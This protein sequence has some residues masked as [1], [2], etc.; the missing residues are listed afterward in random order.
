MTGTQ[1]IVVKDG[2]GC[3]SAAQ[4]FTLTQP[5]GTDTIRATVVAGPIKCNGDKTTVTVSATG[6]TPPYTGAGTF[7]VGAGTYTYKVTDSK[8]NY[9]VITI[10]I[11]EPPALTISVPIPTTAPYNTTT[12]VAVYASGGTGA[13]SYSLN[14]NTFQSNNLF[15][16]VT[17]GNHLAIV[18]DANACTAQ[19]SFTIAP[20]TTTT[21]SF[22]FEI[23]AFPN[24][25]HKHF[26]L[27]V[28]SGRNQRI[29]I[30]VYNSNGQLVYSL[31]DGAPNNDYN[32]GSNFSTGM[33]YVK[34]QQGTTVQTLKN[35]KL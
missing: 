20:A 5:S 13:F 8:G 14:D 7:T 28:K 21:D 29:S 34:V 19:Q 9:G 26:K 25:S 6:G 1:T 2:N 30:Y 22:K 4:N 17:A 10:T 18:K 16:N 15:Y 12:R 32:F 23:K 33:F 27:R 35:M 11:T 24:P 3:S 31:L